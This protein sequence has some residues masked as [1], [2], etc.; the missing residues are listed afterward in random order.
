[1]LALQLPPLDQLRQ[2]IATLPEG[3]TREKSLV[4]KLRFLVYHVSISFVML[5]IY[6]RF[7]F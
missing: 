5:Q 2:R 4:A 3:V 1:M 7:D 6:Q